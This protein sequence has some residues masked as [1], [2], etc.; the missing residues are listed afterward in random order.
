MDFTTLGDAI[1]P[2]LLVAV[3]AV[4]AIMWRSIK[5][6]VAASETKLDDKVLEAV[7]AAFSKDKATDK[8]AE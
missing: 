8:A 1:V 2:G 3:S 4:V 6:A 7:E 5:K